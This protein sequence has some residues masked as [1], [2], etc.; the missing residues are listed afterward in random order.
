MKKQQEYADKRVKKKVIPV[1]SFVVT[2]LLLGLFTTIQMQVI[3]DYIDFTAIPIYK[4]AIVIGVW[5]LV[6]VII[7]GVI[8]YQIQKNYQKPI[9]KFSSAASRVAK[10]DFSVYVAPYHTPDKATHLDVVM[11]DFNKM[12]EELGSIETLKTDFFSNVSHEFKTPLA[13]IQNNAELLHAKEITQEQRLASSEV[14]IQSTKRLSNLITNMLKMNKLEK[15][16]ITPIPQA[17]DLC[18]QLCECALQ[19]EDMWEKK[20]IDFV[21]DIED[22]VIIEA[23]AGLLEIVW[24]NLFSN[25]IKFT[26]E[27]GSIVLTQGSDEKYVT[28]TVQDTGCGMAKDTKNKAFEKFFQGDESHAMEGNGL[29][30]AL[31]ERILELSSG[32]ISVI[33]EL[34]KGS[35]FSVILPIEQKEG[36]ADE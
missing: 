14:I 30:L 22:K 34:G 8:R 4:R 21:V 27:G 1:S 29:G 6:A 25:A 20:N 36:I 18:Q 11:Q 3:G 12:V 24:N 17:Y 26:P 7:I 23:D 35:T 28:V 9:E 10:G 2:V 5:L 31:V 32:T 16:T 15:Q 13:V 33:S 19:H